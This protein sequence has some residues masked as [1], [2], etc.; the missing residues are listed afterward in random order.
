MTL[1]SLHNRQ[2]ISLIKQIY[3]DIGNYW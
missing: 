3:W 1:L 2:N